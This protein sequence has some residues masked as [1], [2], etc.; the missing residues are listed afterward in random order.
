MF[1]RWKKKRK[2]SDVEIADKFD[3]LSFDSPN[4]T[5][6]A[7]DKTWQAVMGQKFA[8]LAP[9]QRA[10]MPS[11]IDGHGVIVNSSIAFGDF[12]IDK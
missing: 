12:V 8:G 1:E 10:L 2:L 3:G 4:S 9:G 7:S 5:F 11:S 6:A